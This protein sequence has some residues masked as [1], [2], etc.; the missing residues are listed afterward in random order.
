MPP[1]AASGAAPG[2]VLLQ[3]DPAG[4]VLLVLARG[5]V[6]RLA[7]G[8][9][10]LDHRARVNSGHVSVSLRDDAGDRAGADGATALADREP[11]ADFERDRGDQLD[12]HVDVVAGHDHL[13][14]VGEAD[15]ARDVGRAQVEL[16]PVPV[17][18]RGVAAALLLGQDVDA[19]DEV[20]VGGDRAR[21]GQDLAA[22]DVVALDAPQQE[23][24]VVARLALLEQLLEHLDPGH[25]HLAGGPDA[26]DLDLFARP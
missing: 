17:V 7:L 24:D 23:A 22:L 15:G 6:P 19:G 9:G 5:V 10:K 18:E 4:I 12:G 21:L 14:P 8:A 20:G 3:L 2:A 26:D 13:G 25:D 16:G 1:G 11:L